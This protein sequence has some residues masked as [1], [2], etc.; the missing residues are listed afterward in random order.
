[1]R[2]LPLLALT[3]LAACDDPFAL[4]PRVENRADT[5]SL[6]AVSGTPVNRP[7]AYLM[8]RGGFPGTVVRTDRQSSFDIVFDIDT[9]GLALLL[10]TG[11]VDLGVGSGVLK[12]TQPFDSITL[13]PTTGYQD[14]L[15]V[16][17]TTGDAAVIRSPLV[18]CSPVSAP[19]PLYAKLRVLTLDLT[20]R[21]MDFEILENPNCG[22]RGLEP[23]LPKR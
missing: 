9:A 20:E 2:A 5:V 4:T 21:R 22:F 19:Y 13:A 8:S 6:W 10:P 3:L 17:L 18:Q 11:A 16:A 1:M 7:S 14:T 23:G 12:S 15:G